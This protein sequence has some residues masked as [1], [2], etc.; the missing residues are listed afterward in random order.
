MGR[1]VLYSQSPN[2]CPEPYSPY[3]ARLGHEASVCRPK[4]LLVLTSPQPNWTWPYAPRANA[5]Q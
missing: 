4:S 1:R 3:R 2:R 5:G